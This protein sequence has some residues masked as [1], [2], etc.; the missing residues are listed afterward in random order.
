MAL[1][2]DNLFVFNFEINTSLF[3]SVFKGLL[4]CI[5]LSQIIQS[6]GTGNQLINQHA[7]LIFQEVWLFSLNIQ[8]EVFVC[9]FQK[10]CYL[11]NFFYKLQYY[12]GL[13]VQN[14]KADSGFLFL[15]LLF[16]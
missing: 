13:M 7:Y 15:L 10:G 2:F 11:E 12:Y 9:F 3:S 6:R 4:T 16:F 1:V 14:N 5:Y 8:N